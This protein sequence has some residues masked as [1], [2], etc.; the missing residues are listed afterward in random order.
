MLTTAL[1]HIA[2]IMDG[3]GRYAKKHHIPTIQGHAKGAETMKSM[4]RLCKKMGIKHATFWAFSTENWKRPK[5]WLDQYFKL[6]DHYLAKQSEVFFENEVRFKAVGN[7]IQLP[8]ST[9]KLLKKLEEETKHFEGMQVNIALSY[10]GRDDLA[11]AMTH[12]GEKIK[13]GIISPESIS[14]ALIAEHLD[15]AGLPDIDILVRTAGDQ[16]LSNFML[17]QLAY[18]ELYFTQTLWPDL[19]EEEIIQIVKDFSQRERRYGNYLDAPTS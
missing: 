1:K 2:F 9:Q 6:A 3:N 11:R 17:Y 19:S 16:R 14:E 12:I 10:G 18:T 4:V 5:I 13:Q 15:T 8:L 7:L